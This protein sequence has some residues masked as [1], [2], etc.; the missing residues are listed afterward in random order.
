MTQGL[1]SVITPCYNAEEYISK[2]LDSILDQT[3]KSIEMYVVDDGS[4]DNSA[5]IIKAYIPKFKK[6]GYTLHYAFQRNQGQSFA[7]NNALKQV[8]GEYLVWP[9]ADD[10]YADKTT[11]AQMVN[12][13]AKSDD[14]VSMVR[15]EYNIVDTD[16]KLVDT[17]EVTD[18]SRYKTD[19]FED[20]VFSENGFWYPPGGY[21]AKMSKVDQLIPKRSI[22]TERQA[23]QNYQLYTPLLYRHKIITITEKLYTI[24]ARKDSHSRLYRS[25]QERKRAYYRTMDRTLAGIDMPSD[26]RKY[27]LK[28]AKS[29]IDGGSTA[30][31]KGLR[32]LFKRG[33]KAILPYGAIVVL[34]KKGLLAP[35]PVKT[36][37]VYRDRKKTRLE[38][39][40][41]YDNQIFKD[42][43]ARG[44]FSK[45][46]IEGWMLFCAH[47]LEKAMS[48]VNFEAGHNFHRLEQMEKLLTEYKEKQFDKNSF[49]YQY[50]LASIKKYI[51]LHE[52]HGFNTDDIT[53]LLGDYIDEA[54]SSSG[55]L[56]GYKTITSE[57]KK[58]NK[59]KNFFELQNG[60]YSVREFSEKPVDISDVQ[61][62][63]QLAMKAPAVC[64]R[65]PARVRTI[66]DQDKIKDILSLQGG[67][68]GYNLPSCLLLV[69]VDVRNYVGVNERNQP[70]I[71]GGSFAMSL[72]LSLEYYGLAACPLHAMFMPEKDAKMRS[73]LDIKNPEYM[74]MFIAVGHFNKE[75]KVAVSS[76]CLGREI[77]TEYL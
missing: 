32:T 65:Q 15:V 17:H 58:K 3:Y 22:Y 7:I 2:L 54:Q 46:N 67:F 26:Y 1:V 56:S 77:T 70:F 44:D 43:F 61:E 69:S 13:L 51:E 57:E 35:A 40:S 42:G 66:M 34:R 36:R 21:M 59:T 10:Y 71:D 16:G 41:D 60:R 18:V 52:E 6:K 48:R 30:K 47:V 62:S 53:N 14:D 31:K 12:V 8:K 5:E 37:K 19:L 76:R 25:L 72:M 24:V 38:E 50:A 64:N 4:T 68:Q 20:A 45:E 33:L 29:K 39:V 49:A 9:D 63:I 73:I 27:L 74:V 23:G 28:T 11:I 55:E 75:N